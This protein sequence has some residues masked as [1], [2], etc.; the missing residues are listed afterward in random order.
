MSNTA[1]VFSNL[2]AL[3]TETKKLFPE[4]ELSGSKKTKAQARHSEKECVFPKG[5][6]GTQFSEGGDWRRSPVSNMHNKGKNETEIPPSLWLFWTHSRNVFRPLVFP[7]PAALL[8]PCPHL[9]WR[10]P[11]SDHPKP[12]QL[13]VHIKPNL[14]AHQEQKSKLPWHR[15][16][17]PQEVRFSS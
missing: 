5:E 16:A 9:A 12:Q 8:H 1:L 14:L 15:L 3:L 6:F 11:A 4:I 10:M 17:L 13:R 2:W 7:F